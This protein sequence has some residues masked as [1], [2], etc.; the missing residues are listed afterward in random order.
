LDYG[1][2]PEGATNAS[3]APKL[4]KKPSHLPPPK[5]DKTLEPK[6]V[7]GVA[8]VLLRL[9]FMFGEAGPVTDSQGRRCFRILKFFMRRDMF[10]NAD[11]RMQW[12]DRILA[13][14]DQ[15]AA[16]PKSAQQQQQMDQ[17][18]QVRFFL[19]QSAFFC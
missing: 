10:P 14:V 15:T 18:G 5:D 1:E 13:N 9:T 4:A 16:P 11:M 17:N 8:S 6:V 3:A 19:K 12:M 7:D 2:L